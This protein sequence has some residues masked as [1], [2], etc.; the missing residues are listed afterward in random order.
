MTPRCEPPNSITRETKGQMTTNIATLTPKQKAKL[1]AWRD[2][3]IA[4]GLSTEPASRQAA[5]AAYRACYRFA[6]LRDDVPI[7]WVQSPI[8]G[9]LV[10]PLAALA[11]KQMGGLRRVGKAESAVGSAVYSANLFWHPWLGG[12]LWS[13]WP[14]FESFFREEC[15]LVFHND[16]S[17]PAAAYA[18]TSEHGCYWWPNRYFIIACERPAAIHRD[19]AGRLHDASGPAISWPDGWGLHSWH[20]TTVPEEWIEDRNSL[21]ARMALAEPNTERRRAACE[22]LG[23]STILAEIG[24]RSIDIDPDPE[25]GELLEASLPDAPRERFLKVQCATGRTFMLPVPPDVETA[26]AANAWTFDLPTDLF[27]TKEHR[28]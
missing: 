7:V 21:T 24:A 12:C 13:A 10:A 4:I 26:L 28:T 9:A 6:G 1:P 25:I 15:G 2:K 16:L 23:W 11:L 22:I 17:A 27:K 5:E 8:V 19:D 20:G 18:A 3:W 14:S